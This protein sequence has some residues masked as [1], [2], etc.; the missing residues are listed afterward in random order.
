[1]PQTTLAQPPWCSSVATLPLS[2]QTDDTASSA[3]LLQLCCSSVSLQTTLLAQP[4]WCSSVAALLQLCL[5][6]QTGD[7]AS[8][9]ALLQLCC[10]SVV[11]LS[12]SLQTDDTASSGR[13]AAAQVAHVPVG[14]IRACVWLEVWHALLQLCCS[15]VAALGLS[16]RFGMFCCSKLFSKRCCRILVP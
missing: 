1:M 16:E 3:A 11:A 13:G 2:L 14:L 5:S 10:S 12:L 15:S 4:L 8:S 7:T 9:A 6:L